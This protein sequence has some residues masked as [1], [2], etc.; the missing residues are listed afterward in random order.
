MVPSL[1]HPP[2]RPSHRHVLRVCGRK[3]A[4]G[5]ACAVHATVLAILLIDCCLWTA[6]AVV[7]VNGRCDDR[8]VAAQC[9]FCSH[10]HLCVTAQPG[11]SWQGLF[12]DSLAPDRPNPNLTA[13]NRSRASWQ[14]HPPCRHRSLPQSDKQNRRFKPLGTTLGPQSVCDQSSKALRGSD[15]RLQTHRH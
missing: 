12:L 9:T 4:H 8:F 7:N 10:K 1:L 6:A 2:L 3:A 11:L 14:Q 13:H 15:P 5:L